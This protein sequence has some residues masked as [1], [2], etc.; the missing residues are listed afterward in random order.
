MASL[1]RSLNLDI[2]PVEILI[3]QQA[4]KGVMGCQR[5]A[6]GAIE[7]DGGGSWR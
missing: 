6:I 2:E 3:E 7:A 4:K 1:L 5:F